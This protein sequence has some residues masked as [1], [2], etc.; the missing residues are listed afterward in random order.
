MQEFQ[1]RGGFSRVLNDIFN[2]TDLKSLELD[3]VFQIKK[4]CRE[5]YQ[6]KTKMSEELIATLDALNNER[7]GVLQMKRK[8]FDL[9]KY[10]TAT[11][12]ERLEWMRLNAEKDRVDKFKQVAMQ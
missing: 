4:F 2:P 5:F 3:S 7:P 9:D 10:K 11:K 12:K 1:D 6:R 8:H